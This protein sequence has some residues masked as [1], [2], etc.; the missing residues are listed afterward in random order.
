MGYAKV[1]RYPQRTWY[2]MNSEVGD[3]GVQGAGLLVFILIIVAMFYLHSTF[4][5]K[6][7]SEEFC[8]DAI[9]IGI[10]GAVRS[11]GVYPLCGEDT[12]E[13]LIERAGGIDGFDNLPIRLNDVP[14]EAGVRLILKEDDGRLEV[15]PDDISA[16]Y[17]FTLG[18]PIS[19]NRE[20]EE[21]LTAIP[22]IGPKLAGAIVRDRDTRGEYKALSEIKDVPGIG[23]KTYKKIAPYVKL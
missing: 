7:V 1:S 15:C 16:F 21:G 10:E 23:D 13:L 4:K 11:P 18:I 6:T 20:S 14:I 8:S 12:M 17:K 9:Y 2:I 3:N 19:L 5:G 22:G